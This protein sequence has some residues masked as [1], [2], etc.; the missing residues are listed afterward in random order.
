MRWPDD[1]LR[2]R[3]LGSYADDEVLR[4]KRRAVEQSAR[5]GAHQAVWRSNLARIV[6]DGE[7][8]Q[9]A[10]RRRPTIRI[11]RCL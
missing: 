1:T 7:V 11:P 5:L 8:A 10:T 2:Y 6:A 3:R 4:M 9:T